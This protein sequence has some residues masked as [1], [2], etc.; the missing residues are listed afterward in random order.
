MEPCLTLTM[1]MNKVKH[2]QKGFITIHICDFNVKLKQWK[3]WTLNRSRNTRHGQYRTMQGPVRLHTW[4]GWWA[5]SERRSATMQLTIWIRRGLV[6]IWWISV[7]FVFLVLCYRRS[8]RHSQKG[9]QWLVVWGTEREDRTF[10]ISLCRGVTCVEQREIVRCLTDWT[11]RQQKFKFHLKSHRLISAWLKI[12]L[13]SIAVKI[14]TMWIFKQVI[15]FFHYL[16]Q[17]NSNVKYLIKMY[18]KGLSLTFSVPN[19]KTTWEN[20]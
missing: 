20:K 4:T 3:I 16:S 17:T 9:R 5:D 8:S 1:A 15:V 14:Q 18:F 19:L 6:L 13:F 7:C 10:P 12:V 2:Q 11:Q